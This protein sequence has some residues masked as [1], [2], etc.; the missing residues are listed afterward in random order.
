MGV[1]TKSAGLER[2]A[3]RRLGPGQELRSALD[4]L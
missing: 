1:T 2:Q 4:D 3:P